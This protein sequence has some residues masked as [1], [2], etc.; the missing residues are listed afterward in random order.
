MTEWQE[1]RPQQQLLN[2]N[3]DGYRLTLEPLA[4]YSLKFDENIH[5]Q[6]DFQLDNDLYTFNGIKG[7]KSSNQLHRN[8][9]KDTDELYFFD[10]H[11]SIRQINLS[12]DQSLSHLQ[13]PI[14]M[15]Q[16]PKNTLHGSMVFI[17]DSLV[18]GC[19]GR[20]KLFLLNTN[21]PKWKLLHDEDFE[22]FVTS[23]IRLLHAVNHEGL[24]HAVV[25]FIQTDC[26]LLWVTF[27]IGSAN[28]VKLTRRRILKGKKWPDFVALESNGQGVFVAAEGLYKFTFDSLIEVN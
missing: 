19:D 23:P 1:F 12:S 16:L 20:S 21:S 11:H 4:Q 5:V 7:F 24:V 14:S 28:E 27:S 17:T 8:P 13:Q 25:G 6:K 3:F 9:W 18:I 10:Q 26:Q 22:E 15:Y 2:S